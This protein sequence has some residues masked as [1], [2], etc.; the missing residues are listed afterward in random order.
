MFWLL[1]LFTLLH[2]FA[3]SHYP[4]LS[5]SSWIFP[6]PKLP[7]FLSLSEMAPK[8]ATSNIPPTSQVRTKRPDGH[9]ELS[10]L[11]SRVET[12]PFERHEGVLGWTMTFLLQWACSIKPLGL[13]LLMMATSL[14]SKGCSWLDSGYLFLMVAPSQIMP[15]AWRYLFASYILWRL[16]LKKEMKIL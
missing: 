7:L 5:P 6:S 1:S 13:E 3:L 15:N 16:V 9:V 14:Y 11:E 10:P 12:A 2:T 4:P 8:K